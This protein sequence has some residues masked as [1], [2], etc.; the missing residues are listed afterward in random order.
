[1]ALQ[2]IL[3]T[4]DDLP[5]TIK[6]LY[7]KKDD[8][9]FHLE[10][11][12]AVSREKLEEF[13][14][15]NVTLTESNKEMQKQLQA[16]E[17]VDPAKYKQFMDKFQTDEEKKLIKDGNIEEVIKI[18]T[19]AIRKDFS[20]KLA[21]K[22]TVIVKL[23]EDSKKATGEKDGYIVEAE[24]RK[25]LDSPDLGFQP[26]V[27]D[28]LKDRVLKEFVHKDGKVVRVKPDGSLIYGKNGDAEG[29]G[30]FVAT[31]A[32]EHPYL[33]K[34]SSG[35]GAHNDTT[36]NGHKN[37]QKTMTR[38]EFEKMDPVKKSDY[39]LKEKGVLTD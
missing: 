38:S 22:E 1:M 35:G 5:E 33:V 19:E 6:P 25:A 23:T 21:A 10:V 28:I 24:M 17:G 2:L 13:R 7:K 4:I 27:G 34:P 8:G 12:G 29:I 3:T 39:M 9:K 36:N 20:D 11:E 16:F 14:S 30:E 15:N 32:K 31:Y 26:G 37:G 18:R